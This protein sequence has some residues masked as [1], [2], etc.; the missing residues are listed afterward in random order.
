MDPAIIR[1]ISIKPHFWLGLII[2]TCVC[3]G[4]FILWSLGIHAV[5]PAFFAM[6]SFFITGADVKNI[7]SILI[8]AVVGLAVALLFMVIVTPVSIA[9]G[10]ATLGQLLLIWIVVFCIAFL[11][12]PHLVP[13]CFNNYAFIYFTAALMLVPEITEAAM[14]G[15]LYALFG[16]WMATAVLGGGGV[17]ALILFLITMA[18]KAGLIPPADAGA[19]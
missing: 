9:L 17:L 4:V 15:G 18:R 10:S 3:L 1:K 7:P 5:W 16:T 8:S 12:D 6:I 13:I 19:H 11:G 2:A 14:A